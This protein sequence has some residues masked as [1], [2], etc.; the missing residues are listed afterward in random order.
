MH[1]RSGTA[2]LSSLA[3][4]ECVF[5]MLEKRNWFWL[6]WGLIVLEFVCSRNA[7]RSFSLRVCV[8]SPC[9]VSMIMK[10]GGAACKLCHSCRTPGTEGEGLVY[11]AWSCCSG[12]SNLHT[13]TTSAD[14]ITSSHW[15]ATHFTLQGSS[16]LSVMNDR[17]TSDLWVNRVRLSLKPKAELNMNM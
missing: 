4:R 16:A 15:P 9:I 10:V 7:L 3:F 13:Y 11:Y 2:W 5:N 8:F 12:F 6:N 17:L 14:D 1:S